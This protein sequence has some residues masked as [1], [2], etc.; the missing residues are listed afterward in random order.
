MQVTIN[1]KRRNGRGILQLLVD[2]PPTL[3]STETSSRSCSTEFDCWLLVYDSAHLLHRIHRPEG[4]LGLQVNR[5][6]DI[7]FRSEIAELREETALRPSGRS[8]RLKDL[9][10]GWGRDRSSKIVGY[11]VSLAHLGFS[12][13]WGARPVGDVQMKFVLL[14]WWLKEELCPTF[15]VFY[16]NHKDPILFLHLEEVAVLG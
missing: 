2:I 15:E 8:L 12:F 13:C 7:I 14:Q 11:K 5:F 6:K 9:V 10:V 1:E 16:R 4:G 3:C